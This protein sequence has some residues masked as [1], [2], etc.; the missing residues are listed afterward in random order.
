MF[1]SSANI[2]FKKW[3]GSI[4]ITFEEKNQYQGFQDRPMQDPIQLQIDT[5]EVNLKKVS[6]NSRNTFGATTL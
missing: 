2:Y 1:E 6:V 5:F 4:N 3:K